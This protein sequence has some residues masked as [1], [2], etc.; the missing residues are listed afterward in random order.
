LPIIEDYFAEKNTTIKKHDGQNTSDSILDI[1]NVVPL[2][3]SS[4]SAPEIP[5]TVPYEKNGLKVTFNFSK[6]KSDESTTSIT[7]TYH[8]TTS[9]PF[10]DFIMEVAVPK[11]IQLQIFSPTSGQ[12]GPF[13][14]SVTQVLRITNSMF[15]TK[16]VLMKLKIIYNCDGNPVQEFV[17][18]ANFPS[19]V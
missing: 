14:S 5:Q 10:T 3:Q 18:V 17:N 9:I 11:Y 1:F 16:P 12:I 13:T 4:V 15:G 6:D 19:N 2:G 7:A 8:N